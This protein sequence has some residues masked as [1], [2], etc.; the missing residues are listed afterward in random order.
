M[1]LFT[2]QH[3]TVP[4]PGTGSRRRWPMCVQ[5]NGRGYPVNGRHHRARAG[6]VAEAVIRDKTG[7]VRH[8]QKMMIAS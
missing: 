6:G 2:L 3:W 1:D 4:V 5:M 8:R 7:N